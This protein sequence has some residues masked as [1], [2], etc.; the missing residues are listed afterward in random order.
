MTEA[1][2][3]ALWDSVC[4]TDAKYTKQFTRG[5]GFKGTATNATWLARQATRA[6]GP[7]GI[8]WGFSV[9]DEKYV[10][11]KPG[12][13]VH[14]VRVK[15]WY[16]LDGV[17]GEIEQYGQ[18]TF[19]GT[20]KS[21][22]YTDEEAPKKSITD[23][24]SKCLS[25]LGFAADIHMG[26]FDDNKYLDERDAAYGESDQQR[27]VPAGAL[28]PEETQRAE[29]QGAAARSICDGFINM[30]LAATHVDE[31]MAILNE[32]I[33]VIDGLGHVEIKRFGKA[34]VAHIEATKPEGI[35]ATGF[36]EAF[37]MVT[38]AHRRATK[39]AAE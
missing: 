1:K 19:V 10:P 32:H 6:F 9:A 27:I 3:S 21:G 5:G 8:G 38:K 11:G 28:G 17:K 16:V 31:I 13:I 39:E 25:L 7:C 26:R 14:V 35:T 29:T 4:T 2:K 18:T 20:T 24:M 30:A 23:G 15:L 36:R 34:V 22:P 12:D 37:A 33:A